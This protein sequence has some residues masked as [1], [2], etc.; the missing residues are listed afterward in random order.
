MTMPCKHHILSNGVILS[1]Q[2]IYILIY[3]YDISR[4]YN[5]HQFNVFSFCFHTSETT[6]VTIW[7]NTVLFKM[8]IEF[9]DTFCVIMHTIDGNLG[10]ENN[11]IIRQRNIAFRHSSIL[12]SGKLNYVAMNH[13][14]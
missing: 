10:A 13:Y 1:S 7:N 5:V 2:V 4:N 14:F 9:K 8:I 6:F 11:I 12:E 3:I